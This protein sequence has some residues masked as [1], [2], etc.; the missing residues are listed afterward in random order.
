MQLDTHSLTALVVALLVASVAVP[1]GATGVQPT[2]Y[3]TS[4]ISGTQEATVVEVTDGDTITVEYDN[5]STDE[6]RLL[7]VDTPEVHTS[8]TPSEFEGVPDTEEGSTC[9][10]YEGEVVALHTGTDTASHL[11]W[12]RTDYTV[13]NNDGDTGYLYDDHGDYA[14][15]KSY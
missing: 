8:N 12:G 14:N 11:Y 10:G 4:S 1:A 13:W 7:G 6:V 9:L 15:S 3:S 2:D 5:E